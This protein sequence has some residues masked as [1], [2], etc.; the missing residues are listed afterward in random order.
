MNK[1]AFAQFREPT[2]IRPDL[3]PKTILGKPKTKEKSRRILILKNPL[4]WT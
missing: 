2:Y 1:L 3:W 4:S